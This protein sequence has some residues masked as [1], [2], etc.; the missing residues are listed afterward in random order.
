MSRANYEIVAVEVP[1]HG[2]LKLRFADGLE[3]EVDVIDHIWG[4]VFER[5]RTVEGF[6]EVY[7]NPDTIT[8]E[9]PGEADLAPDTLYERV[10]TGVWPQDLESAP[11]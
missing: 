9:W 5:V 2:V 11:H 4:P 8:V 3:G 7:V 10:R 6:R 1:R